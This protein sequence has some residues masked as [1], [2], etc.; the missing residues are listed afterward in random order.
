MPSEIVVKFTGTVATEKTLKSSGGTG[1][2]TPTSLANGSARETAKIF[3]GSSQP[4]SG[5]LVTLKTKGASAPTAYAS[6]DVYANFSG[7]AT[8]GTDNAGD[9]SGTD[10]AFPSAGTKAEKLRQLE[11]IGPLIYSTSTGQ[12]TKVVGILPPL[13]P[14]VSLIVDNNSGVAFSGTASDH[15]IILT[16]LIPEI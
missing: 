6:T 4:A 12:Q 11:F 13:K 1:A 10:A 7:S 16:P 5:W 9:A 15:E 2:W 14:Y 8:A 3:L